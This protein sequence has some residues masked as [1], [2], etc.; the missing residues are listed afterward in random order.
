VPFFTQWFRNAEGDFT[1]N[2]AQ[3]KHTA[4]INENPY[5]EKLADMPLQV[6]N[7]TY[8]LEEGDGEVQEVIYSFIDGGNS[9][10]IDQVTEH[11]E[12]WTFTH[13]HGH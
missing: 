13:D 11:S 12:L 7:P 2:L 1:V 8:Q 5:V 3:F 4:T 9:K 10:T 6:G